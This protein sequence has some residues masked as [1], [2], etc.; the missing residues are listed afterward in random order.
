MD[1]ALQNNDVWNLGVDRKSKTLSET[2]ETEMII[3][4]CQ[5]SIIAGEIRDRWFLRKG[6][7][8]KHISKGETI[9]FYNSNQYLECNVIYGICV[10]YRYVCDIGKKR[11]GVEILKDKAEQESRGAILSGTGAEIVRTDLLNDDDKTVTFGIYTN[12]VQEV[13]ILLPTDLIQVTVYTLMP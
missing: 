4:N 10:K 3:V 5:K 9:V 13:P 8:Y 1:I 7:K 6:I 12:R 11:Y 2:K